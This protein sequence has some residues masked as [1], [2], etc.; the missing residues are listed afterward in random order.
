MVFELT[1]GG[2]GTNWVGIGFSNDNFM[3]MTDI[4][5]GYVSGGG[6]SVQDRYAT[7]KALP[8]I[9]SD[10]SQILVSDGSVADGKLTIQFQRSLTSIDAQDLSLDAPRYLLFAWGPLNGAGNDITKHTSDKSATSSRVNLQACRFE[11]TIISGKKRTL[12]RE[13]VNLSI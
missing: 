7:L 1:L 9:D 11:G 10:Q 6:A 8:P 12:Q 4:V 2:G 13:K 3:P 5:T